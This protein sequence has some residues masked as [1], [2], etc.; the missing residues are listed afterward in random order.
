MKV[1]AISG[2]LRTGS[3][4]T[5][6]VSASL[7]HAPSD[8]EIEVYDG[9]GSLPL[10]D[11]DLDTETPPD[12]VV[13]LHRRIRDADGLLIATPEY[14]YSIPG[15]LKNCIDWASRPFEGSR[16]LERKPIAIMG[17]SP[18]NFGSVRAQL[19]LRHVFTWT[20]SRVVV[21]PEV[22][23]FLAHERFDA[24]GKLTDETSAELLRGLLVELSVVI[25]IQAEQSAAPAG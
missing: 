6:L 4:N 3:Y 22:I 17:A 15:P 12:A 20:D 11:G 1:L 19:H 16:S 7:D 25:R 8:M 5:M 14:N 10:Y 13:D 18:T 9:L 2:S 23:M 21:K 24:S